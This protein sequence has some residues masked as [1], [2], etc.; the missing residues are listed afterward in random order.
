MEAQNRRVAGISYHSFF[1]NLTADI[2]SSDLRLQE[3]I[4]YLR[5]LQKP[6]LLEIYKAG[7]PEWFFKV[8]VDG[9]VREGRVDLW[10]VVDDTL[11][12]IDYK[13]GSSYFSQAAF[14][15]MA[16]YAEVL[17][18]KRSQLNFKSV[19]LAAIYPVE[20]KCLIE[21]WSGGL[22]VSHPVH[23]ENQIR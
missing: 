14:E 22:K 16:F 9:V 7:F 6:N 1:E 23:P 13:T 4:E 15:Q 18:D 17:S 19:Q 2:Q 11:W 20:K 12:V 5:N 21:E 3:S 10:G 8:E